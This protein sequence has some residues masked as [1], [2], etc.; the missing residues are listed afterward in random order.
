VPD[1]Q[2]VNKINDAILEKIQIVWPE[3]IVQNQNDYGVWFAEDVKGVPFAQLRLP[4][5]VVQ[6][7]EFRPTSE[8]GISGANDIADYQIYYV[9]PLTNTD[10]NLRAKIKSMINRFRVRTEDLYYTTSISGGHAQTLQ[11]SGPLVGDQ[12]DLN[13]ELIQRELKARAAALNVQIL[14]HE[15]WA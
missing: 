2:L 12:L 13:R 6:M 11:V 15:E 10:R 14:S 8:W 9:R 5:C 7:G 4:Y 1:D 3:V